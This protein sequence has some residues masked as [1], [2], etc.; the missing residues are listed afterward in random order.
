META[1]E[2]ESSFFE[3]HRSTN[4]IDFENIGVIEAAGNSNQTVS[5][6]LDDYEAKSGIRYYKLKMVDLNGDFNYSSIVA[7]NFEESNIQVVPNPSNGSFQLIGLKG[8]NQ[9]ELLD[10]QGKVLKQL[11]SNQSNE[12]FYLNQTHGIY[13]LRITSADSTSII[14]V[15]IGE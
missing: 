8:T 6:Q 4:G 12:Y 9:I 13:L 1:S 10:L 5:Y 3:V 2:N 14:R 7:T 11:E 15:V